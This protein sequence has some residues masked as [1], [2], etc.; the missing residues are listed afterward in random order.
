MTTANMDSDEKKYA[1]YFK[2][3]YKGYWPAVNE[4]LKFHPEGVRARTSLGRGG[5][6]LH[7]AASLGHL[8]IVE[9]LVKL[10][11]ED[12]KLTD[13]TGYTALAVAASTGITEIS[14]S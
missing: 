7:V 1:P 8:H 6:A 2:A 9:E 3:V 10:T 4:F 13:D 5:T 14:Y 11:S 12:V